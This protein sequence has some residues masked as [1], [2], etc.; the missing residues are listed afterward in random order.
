M[1]AEPRAVFD[2]NVY[3]QALINP[4]GPSGQCFAMA[5]QERI[6][7][8]YGAFALEE[9]VRATSNARFRARFTRITDSKVSSL[10]ANIEMVGEFYDEPAEV[11]SYER[12]PADAYY[13]NLALASAATIVV[14]HDRDLLDLMDEERPESREFRRRFPQV[15]IIEPHQLLALV[16][17]IAP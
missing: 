4:D 9:F 14:S 11:F 15:E 12:D 10:I 13:V 8:C 16:R 3:L 17:S 5:L 1:T 6:A 7:L 2:C